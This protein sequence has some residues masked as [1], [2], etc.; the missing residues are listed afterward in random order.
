LESICLDFPLVK[1]RASLAP[2]LLIGTC[3]V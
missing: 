3:E 2:N 1:L